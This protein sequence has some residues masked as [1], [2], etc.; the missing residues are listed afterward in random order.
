MSVRILSAV[1]DRGPED[2][3]ELLVLLALAD[4]CN[5]DGECWPSI[6]AVARKARM[7]D[8]GVQKICA[9]LAEQGWLRI[10]PNRG[11][12]G[13]NLYRL[14]NPH[15]RDPETGPEEPTRPPNTVHPEPGSPPNASA[16]PPNPVRETPEPRSDEPSGNHQEPPKTRAGSSFEDFWA[17]CPNPV[18]EQKARIAFGSLSKAEQGAAIGNVAEWYAWF[19]RKYPAASTPN[20]AT[21]LSGRRWQDLVKGARKPE[22]SDPDAVLGFW[23][24]KINGSG[25][26]SSSAVGP[27]LC[28][29]LVERGMVT[30]ARL[31][32]RGLA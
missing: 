26:V 6:P 5:D 8:R 18:S 19:A 17:A 9:R 23:A 24:E 25:Y 31:R 10:E 22:P 21:Y 27:R 12:R 28:R 30:E 3:G 15:A 13:C 2:K 14:L 20:P 7:S 29:E 16:E 11:R 1:W 4:Y 32:E